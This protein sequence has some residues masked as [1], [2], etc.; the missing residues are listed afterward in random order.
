MHSLQEGHAGK[1][2]KKK[3]N[4]PIKYSSPLSIWTWLPIRSTCLDY[5]KIS[6]A[7]MAKAE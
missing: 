4:S 6:Y 3:T 2:Q 7:P 1:Y 5:I